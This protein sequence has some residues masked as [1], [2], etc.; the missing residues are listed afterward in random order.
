MQSLL[1]SPKDTSPVPVLSNSWKA[2]MKRASGTHSTD[3]KAR[4]SWNEIN[5]NE[6]PEESYIRTCTSSIFNYIKL[7]ISWITCNYIIFM[8]KTEFSKLCHEHYHSKVL[9]FLKKLTLLFDKD[10][11]N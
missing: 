1:F 5:L 8:Y 2:T 6:K 10:T 7:N 11:L 4:N 9:L 3:S